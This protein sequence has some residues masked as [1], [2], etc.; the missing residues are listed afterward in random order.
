MKKILLSII[1]FY[2]LSIYAERET[3]VLR[4]EEAANV[5]SNSEIVRMKSFSTI[6]NYIKFKRGQEFSL[7]EL[8]NWLQHYFKSDQKVG[9]A[10]LKEEKDQLGYTHYRFQQ[11]INNVPVIYSPC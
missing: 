3:I 8:E 10:L 4:G 6:P 7:S 2:G 9:L 5:V 1:L 11:T